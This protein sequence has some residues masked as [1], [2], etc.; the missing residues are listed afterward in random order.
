MGWYRPS[1]GLWICVCV[2]VCVCMC[3]HVLL[4]L[5]T[6]E[7]KLL[8]IQGCQ[9][10]PLFSLQANLTQ[11]HLNCRPVMLGRFKMWTITSDWK[12][13]SERAWHHQAVWHCDS[14]VPAE[15]HY[16]R[17][18]LLVWH[19]WV[20]MS[21]CTKMAFFCIPQFTHSYM[22]LCFERESMIWAWESCCHSL[23][24]HAI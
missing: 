6:W 23:F 14:P 7:M 16:H 21:P 1:G 20:S 3:V 15:R 24:F 18:A 4:L 12:S 8:I 22:Q 2:C 11:E 13:C 5:L 9:Q 19:T 17:E 10:I